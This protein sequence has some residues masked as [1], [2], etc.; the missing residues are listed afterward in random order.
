MAQ[1]F[2]G[3]NNIEILDPIGQFGTRI[4]GGKDSA[5]PRYIFTKL[6]KISTIIFNKNDIPILKSQTEEGMTTEPEFLYTSFTYDSYK[7]DVKV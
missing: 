2:V 3:S 1:N 4:Q 6:N 7:T 5:Q